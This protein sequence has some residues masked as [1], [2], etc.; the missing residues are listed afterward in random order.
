MHFVRLATLYSCF[1]F[2]SPLVTVL[3]QSPPLGSPV[4]T[5]EIDAFINGLLSD[6]SSPG[7]LSVAVVRKAANGTWDVET[8]GYGLAKADG[9]N[10][11]DRT[12][13]SIGSNSKVCP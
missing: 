9:T 8:K 13:F 10:V 4:L 3:A 6:W 7:G 11:T 2:A 1:I 5:P 12:L